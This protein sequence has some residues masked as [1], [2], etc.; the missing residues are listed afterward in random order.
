MSSALASCPAPLLTV[1]PILYT[2]APTSLRRSP[3]PS[4]C[5]RSSVRLELSISF[6]SVHSHRPRLR[7]TLAHN[8]PA[9]S[10]MR[11]LV[12]SS[13]RSQMIDVFPLTLRRASTP[14]A[15]I[16]SACSSSGHRLR[17]FDARRR[18]RGHLHCLV[19]PC[20]PSDASVA[21]AGHLL[22]LLLLM[23]RI[24]R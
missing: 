1:V 8:G 12:F 15:R 20:F 10:I 3:P 6:S 23:G 24:R 22:L 17:C 18:R 2:S 5:S 21:P 7:V 19:L 11:L 16:T 13:Q 9:V 4:L 14:S